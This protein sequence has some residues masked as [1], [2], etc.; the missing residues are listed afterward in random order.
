MNNVGSVADAE[1]GSA[2]HSGELQSSPTEVT[3]SSATKK[4]DSTKAKKEKKIKFSWGQRKKKKPRTAAGY[5]PFV[6]LPLY[7]PN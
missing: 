2:V 5:K 1:V 3:S 6:T 7:L 4:L